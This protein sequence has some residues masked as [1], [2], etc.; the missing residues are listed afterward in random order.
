MDAKYHLFDRLSEEA[1]QR[2]PSSALPVLGVV[3]GILHH[4]AAFITVIVLSAF[5]LAFGKELFETACL[6]ASAQAGT[7]GGAGVADA[8][9]R[10]R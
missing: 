1:R 6:A 7:L 9:H 4:L 5:F 8:P 10:G 2:I 3:G